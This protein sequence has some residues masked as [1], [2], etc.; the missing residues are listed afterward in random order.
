MGV[1]EGNI[2]AM[3]VE[4]TKGKLC[5]NYSYGTY[6]LISSSYNVPGRN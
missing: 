1:E 4:M 3:D 6:I 2:E 5:M